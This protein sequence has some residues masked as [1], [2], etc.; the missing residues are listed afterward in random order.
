MQ[1]SVENC[2]LLYRGKPQ[3][4]I[5]GEYISVVLAL[6]VFFVCA[7]SA[8]AISFF[9]MDSA[10]KSSI[11][12][13]S[14]TTATCQSSFIDGT[15]VVTIIKIMLSIR[16]ISNYQCDNPPRGIFLCISLSFSA[17]I[18]L[19][20]SI[21]VCWFA[22]SRESRCLSISRNFCKPTH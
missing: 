9:D 18:C 3:K 6:V 11:L 5:G 14:S 16:L 22:F 8:Y 21:S 15:G 13:K 19:Y 10:R 7:V 2:C 1:V 20:S 4:E 12:D 17:F